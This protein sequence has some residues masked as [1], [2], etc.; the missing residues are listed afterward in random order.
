[1]PTRWVSVSE[2]RSRTLDIGKN[3]CFAN[4]WQYFHNSLLS[5]GRVIENQR[6]GKVTKKATHFPQIWHVNLE[7]L[8]FY[9]LTSVKTESIQNKNKRFVRIFLFYILLIFIVLWHFVEKK[10]NWRK[11]KDVRFSE[12]ITQKL[13]SRIT[14]R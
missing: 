3:T 13:L 2:F 5:E 14:S 7:T 6:F 9:C 8:F 1:M 11:Y 10:Q 4:E 12:S